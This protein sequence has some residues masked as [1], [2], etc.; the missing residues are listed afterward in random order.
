MTVQLYHMQG[1]NTRIKQ[2]FEVLKAQAL[3]SGLM[4]SVP[5]DRTKKSK[6]N[7]IREFQKCVIASA[8]FAKS[9]NRKTSQ[10]HFQQMNKEVLKVCLCLF[11]LSVSVLRGFDVLVKDLHVVSEA[12][13]CSDGDS[14]S[15]G[16]QRRPQKD[17]GN[18]FPLTLH[19]MIFIEAIQ[20]LWSVT[21]SLRNVKKGKNDRSVITYHLW[22]GLFLIK[23]LK[24]DKSE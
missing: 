14:L 1:C 13:Q 12:D 4:L 15:H 2:E 21:H 3:L 11:P 23:E 19:L 5:R 8:S 16:S 10:N 22:E 24:K 6:W 17:P 7:K 18:I 9:W 20:S